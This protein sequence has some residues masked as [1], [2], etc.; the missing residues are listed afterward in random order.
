MT[1]AIE[2]HI[3]MT[4]RK[5]QIHCYVKPTLNNCGNYEKGECYKPAN[6]NTVIR[7]NCYLLG[8]DKERNT[9]LLT[10]PLPRAGSGGV[11]SEMEA[12]SKPQKMQWLQLTIPASLL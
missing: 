1:L 11:L 4:G 6:V 2:N 5:S 9:M 12:N 7:S 3:K 10:L 8:G